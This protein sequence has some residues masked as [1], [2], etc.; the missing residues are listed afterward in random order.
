MSLPLL[1]TTT[2]GHDSLPSSDS[3]MS[4]RLSSMGLPETLILTSNA[5]TKEISAPRLTKDANLYHPTVLTSETLKPVSTDA[6]Y[7]NEGIVSEGQSIEGQRIPKAVHIFYD[8]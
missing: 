1:Q 5:P 2:V 6:A 7:F 3:T 8:H 4:L